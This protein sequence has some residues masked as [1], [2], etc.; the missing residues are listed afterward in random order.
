MYDGTRERSFHLPRERL[1][2]PP[3][4]FPRAPL[5]S[6]SAQPIPPIDGMRVEGIAEEEEC[7]ETSSSSQREPN[8]NIRLKCRGILSPRG[9]KARN[10]CPY[11]VTTT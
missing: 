11:D 9:E 2:H 8:E 5:L 1:T 4:P 10:A 6:T 3:P 7:R